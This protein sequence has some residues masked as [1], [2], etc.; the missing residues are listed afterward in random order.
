MQNTKYILKLRRCLQTVVH[1]LYVS[2]ILQHIFTPSSYP[3]LVPPDSLSTHCLSSYT[4]FFPFL[5]DTLSR[6]QAKPSTIPSLRSSRYAAVDLPRG[7]AHTAVPHEEI[8]ITCAA[9]HEQPLAKSGREGSLG[10]EL[11]DSSVFLIPETE[12]ERQNCQMFWGH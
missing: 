4:L 1:P 8:T 3:L 11:D 5:L 9:P 2:I 6:L 12:I 10:E 7:V